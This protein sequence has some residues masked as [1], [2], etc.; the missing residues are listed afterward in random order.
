MAISLGLGGLLV[1]LQGL[2]VF[3]PLVELLYR[4]SE[5]GGM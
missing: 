1:L 2:I 5:P 4:V 3:W